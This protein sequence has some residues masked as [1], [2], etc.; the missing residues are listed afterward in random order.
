VRYRFIQEHCKELPVTKMCQILQVSRNGYYDWTQRAKSQ[1]QQ[2]R[3]ELLEQIKQVHRDSRRLYGSPRVFAELKQQGVKVCENTVAKIMKQAG[4][5]SKARRRFVPRTTDSRHGHP[6]PPNRLDRCFEQKR[7]NRAW[8]TDIT[9][10]WTA[11]GW[12]YLAVVMD[13]CSRRIVGW[14]MAEHIKAQLC[15]DALSMA[16]QQRQPEKG[17]MHHSDRGVQYACEDYQRLLE[18]KGIVCSMSRA[19]NCYDNAAMES[20]FS[21]LKRELIYQRSAPYA[22]HEQARSEIFEY[23]ECW[24]NRRRLHSSLGYQS[25]V[26]FEASFN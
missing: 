6:V 16:L 5:C 12:L 3:E 18:S 8:C 2:R 24:Y 14:S 20:F 9:C 13:L 23:I 17:L 10:I 7:L 21:S 19:G 22:T 4:I 11:Q 25:P 15:T 26:Q 1:Q